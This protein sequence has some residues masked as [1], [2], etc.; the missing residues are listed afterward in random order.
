VILQPV[1]W[2]IALVLV[3]L[4]LAALLLPLLRGGARAPSEEAARA[5]VY[6]DHKRQLDEELATGTLTVQEHAA[7]VAEL[8]ARLG[9]ELDAEGSVAT[10]PHPPPVRPASERSR[11]IAAL[12]AV[13]IIPV[14]AIVLYLALGSPD[15]LRARPA[16]AER[17]TEQQIVAMVES[18]AQKMKASPGDPKGWRLLGRSYVA[19][20]RF[21]D[22]ADAYAQAVQ[23]GADDA[24]VYADWAEALALAHND[25]RGEP[26]AL[27]RKALERDAQSVKALALLA[28]AAYERG[29]YD[30]AIA[31]WRRVQTALPPGSEDAKQAAAAIAEIERTQANGAASPTPGGTSARNEPAAAPVSPSAGTSPPAA[32][33]S[34]TSS[35]AISGRVELAPALAG[36]VTSGDTL[37]VYARASEGPR[38]PLAILR[39]TAADLPLDFRL[40]DSMSMAAGARL[41]SADRVVVEAR[42]SKS[43]RATPQSGDLAGHSAEVKPG[44]RNVRVT[45]DEVMP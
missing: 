6:R 14:A 27:T 22:A 1:F 16:L 26:E 17:P 12:A 7:A 25:M 23:H 45:I 29:E 5:A 20:G 33:A 38:M 37:F 41:S 18:L 11:F 32:A 9:G 28:T 35:S 31:T 39:R 10:R 24:A 13:A 3:A 34:D 44:A 15:A 2:V 19:L 4:T 42:I 40:D 8:A 21:R 36:R 30:S 43:G